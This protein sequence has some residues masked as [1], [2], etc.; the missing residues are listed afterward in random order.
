[1]LI[2]SQDLFNERARRAIAMAI[3]SQQPRVEYPLVWR[4]PESMLPKPSWVLISQ[5]RTLSTER[6]GDRQLAQLTEAQLE[7]ILEGLWQLIG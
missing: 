6:L 3:T 4:V 7:A 1:V 2:L 5:L